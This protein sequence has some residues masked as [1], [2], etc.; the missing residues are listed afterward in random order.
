[1]MGRMSW[2]RRLGAALALVAPVVAVVGVRPVP[3]WPGFVEGEAI[4]TFKAAADEGAAQRV[5]AGRGAVWVKHFADLSRYRGRH[6]GLVRGAGLSTADLIAGLEQEPLVESAE[7]NYL[8]WG[9]GDSPPNDPLFGQLWALQNTGQRIQGAAWKAGADISFL[10]AWRQAR[11]ASNAVV[12]AVIDS[13]VDYTHPDLAGNVWINPG[14]GLAN[15]R[16]DDGNGYVDDHYGYNFASDN[17]DP[18]DSGTHGTHI[19]GTIAAVGN[20]GLGVIG[21]SPRA[22]IMALRVSND[23]ETFSSSAVVEAIQYA[24]L[25]KKRGV[26]IAAINASYGGG[27]S[28]SA[29]RAALQAAGDAGIVV[30]AA[31]G[32]DA[33]NIDS[34]PLYPASYRL[35]NIIVVAATDQND[36]LA[37]FSNFSAR[38]VDLGAP[39]VNV[40]ST[41]PRGMTSYV[42]VANVTYPAIAMEYAGTTQG[43]TGMIYYCGLGY[44]TNFPAA[45]RSNLALLNRGTLHFSV[46]VANAMAAG[47]VGAIIA[48][49][50]DGSFTGTLE[51]ASDW[52]PAVSISQADGLALAAALP[53]SGTLYSAASAAA[54]YAYQAGTSVATPQVAGAVAFAAMCFPTEPP[55]QRVQ[56]I[57]AQVDPV[58]ALAGLVITGGRLNL[59]RTVDMDEN[60]L[61]DWWEQQCFGRSS[62]TD[63]RADPDGDGLSNLQEFIADTVPTDKTSFPRFVGIQSTAGR[64]QVRWAGGVESRQ[65]LQRTATPGLSGSWADVLTNEPPTLA[66]VG[67][68]AGLATNRASFY[69]LRFERS[70]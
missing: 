12:V 37:S 41:A 32:N 49:N 47:A 57:L 60:D 44:P 27:G 21:V 52:I 59:R 29:E 3:A 45:V 67:V 2:A 19:A 23:G 8:R 48:N 22:Q 6:T 18:M 4:V 17:S 20:N 61:P 13:G 53:A 55:A 51:Y 36:A 50:T 34:N 38:Q 31:A 5:L 63:P 68:P 46:K 64:V 25:M 66:T 15:G 56:R 33:H 42:Q 40:L 54:T 35:P 65:Y 62:G 14:E 28:S 70:Y 69:R 43:A 16:D 30:C 7:P 39:G 11:P 1:M 10:A 26:N 9:L 58:P 24:T